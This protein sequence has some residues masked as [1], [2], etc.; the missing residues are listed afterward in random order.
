MNASAY[1]LT[2]LLVLLLLG[3]S[4]PACLGEACSEQDFVHVLVM[5]MAVMGVTAWLEIRYIFKT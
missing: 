4:I 3:T 5:G 2:L 1:V